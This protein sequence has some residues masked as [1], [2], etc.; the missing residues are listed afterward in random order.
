VYF[1]QSKPVNQP[2]RGGHGQNN[3]FEGLRMDC[4]QTLP[5]DYL[6]LARHPPRIER[7]FVNIGFLKLPETYFWLAH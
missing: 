1:E 5:W 7:K 2:N 6:R 4:R 3:G